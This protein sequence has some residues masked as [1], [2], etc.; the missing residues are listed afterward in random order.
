MKNYYLTFSLLFFTLFAH[1]SF[2]KP[3]GGPSAGLE[4]LFPGTLLDSEGKEVSKDAL[5]GKTVGIY[6][7]GTLVPTMPFFYS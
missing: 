4:E 7:S 5:A 1:T 6:F 2:A 3:S